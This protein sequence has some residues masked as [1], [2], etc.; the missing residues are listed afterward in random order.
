MNQ[1]GIAPIVIIL[2]I[3]GALVAAGG[4]QYW[5]SQKVK[6]VESQKVKPVESQK[7]EPVENQ[8]VK[9]ET[10][11][12][13][14]YRNEKYGFEVKYPN[15][16][17]IIS[18][19]TGDYHKE[20]GICSIIYE[21]K[22]T[23]PNKPKRAWEAGG[24]P[25][26]STIALRVEEADCPSIFDRKA[27]SE[28]YP[29]PQSVLKIANDLLN[30]GFPQDKIYGQAFSTGVSWEESGKVLYG[31]EKIDLVKKDSNFAVVKESKCMTGPIYPETDA[32]ILTLG[33]NFIFNLL[34]AAS[35]YQQDGSF[36]QILSTFKL[37]K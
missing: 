6:P 19:G 7:V 32:Y 8:K 17:K 36:D 37:I 16:F 22:F 13:K 4:V 34:D 3:V 29:F 27:Y 2:I 26:E 28:K 30:S 25:I 10:A 24:K 15:N 9:D 12:W 1:K 20:K 11:N 33:G 21:V 31:C 5:Q 18:E 14:T 23:G 35:D